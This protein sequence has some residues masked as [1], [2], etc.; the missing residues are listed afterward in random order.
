MLNQTFSRSNLEE[1]YDEDNR[2]GKN[3]DDVF[4]PE[5]SA[6]SRRLS[7]KARALRAFKKRQKKFAKY[8]KDVQR[9]YDVLF[10]NVLKQRRDRE[11]RI[12]NSLERV[13]SNINKR[14]FRVGIT[15]N[16]KYAK[17][18]YERDGNPESYYA[19]RQITRNIRSLYKTKPANRNI[20]ISQIQ[21][22]LDDNFPYFIIKTD[23]ASFFESVDQERLVQKL[24]KDQLLSTSSVK[25]IKQILWDFSSLAGTTGKGIPRGL[26]LSSDLAELFLKVIDRQI[27]ELEDVAY[28]ARYVDDIIILVAPNKTTE[29]GK[30]LPKV[31]E[32]LSNHGLALNEAKTFDCDRDSYQKKFNYL[33]YEFTLKKGAVD[34][35]ITHDKFTKLKK[36][37]LSSF[38]AYEKQRHKNSKAAYRLLLKRIKFLTGNTRLVNSK[39]NAF[40]GVYFG[41]PNLNKYSRLKALDLILAAKS[42]GLLSASLRAKLSEMSFERG[43][44]EKPFSK[45]N[46]HTGHTRR[47]EFSQIVEAW[48]HES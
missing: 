17:P 35:D 21:N 30:Y 10:R 40:V 15:K 27:Q 47:D 8:P 1:I 9:R 37:L 29:K 12:S 46:R 28:Y 33:G 24:L 31:R 42:S 7:A 4:F 16:T 13:S 39:R 14:S 6:S 36:R 34:I 3:Q 23:I 2:K 41:N 26:G 32:L 18:V 48:R 45:F 19:L 11:S 5:V 25:I 22:L 38:K 44:R 43:H 20:I